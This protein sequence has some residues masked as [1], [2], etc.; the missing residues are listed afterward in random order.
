VTTRK[1]SFFYSFI[2]LFFIC[3]N[4]CYAQNGESNGAQSL[5]AQSIKAS[6]VN[7]RLYDLITS[8]E[9]SQKEL[10]EV[11]HALTK[12]K[13]ELDSKAL[14]EQRDKLSLRIQSLQKSFE[15]VAI[16]GIDLNDF[17]STQPPKFDWQEEVKDVFRPILDELK[18]LTERP[19]TIE[20][21]RTEKAF[22]ESR[23]PIADNALDKIKAIKNGADDKILI[24]HLQKLEQNWQKRRDDMSHQLRLVTF[25]LDEKLNPP[26]DTQISISEQIEKFFSGRGLNIIYAI[27]AFFL[28]YLFF[29]LISRLLIRIIE[30]KPDHEARFFEKAIQIAFRILSVVLSIFAVIIIFYVQGDWILL[31][32]SLLFLIAFAWTLRQSL[33]R[34]ITEAKLLLNLGPVREN[35]RVVY[36]GIPWRVTAVNFYTTLTNPALAGG[37][38]NL[39]VHVV[40]AL[41]SRRFSKDEP[42]FPC[43][44]GNY[45]MLDDGFLGPVIMQTPE[46]VTMKVRGGSTKTYSTTDFLA[47]NPQNLTHGFGI[48]VTVGFD[49]ADQSIITKDIPQK[50]KSFIADAMANEPFNSSIREFNIEFKEAGASSLNLLIISTFEGKA[51]ENYYSIG[52]F[53]Q[54]ATVD[55]CNQFGWNIPF[56]QLTIHMANKEE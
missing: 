1:L 44:P 12:T 56:N 43:R 35:E 46:M 13:D 28:V 53:L 33:P 18:R 24:S 21:L 27:S 10:V 4:F 34:F 52:R 31:G 48:F 14:L 5:S 41:Q 39:P 51:A 49:Y 38:V 30:N 9:G 32:L 40:L 42:W 20:R 6:N 47:L 54:R 23:L 16:G 25:Q 7:Q 8:I 11:K 45:I 19:R 29:K 55:A 17:E 22:L 26:Q 50:L 15:S 37:I 2:L 36:N 3:P